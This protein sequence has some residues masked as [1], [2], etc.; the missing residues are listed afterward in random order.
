M[1]VVVVV[2]PGATVAKGLARP[3][4][5]AEEYTPQLLG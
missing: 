4:A 2:V 5:T 3:V 1:V